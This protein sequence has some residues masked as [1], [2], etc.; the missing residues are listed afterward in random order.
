MLFAPHPNLPARLVWPSAFDGGGGSLLP[1]RGRMRC[2]GRRPPRASVVRP[3]RGP[4][5][6]AAEPACPVPSAPGWV[7]PRANV[8]LG[9]G[10]T[11]TARQAT[12]RTERRWRGVG[13]RGAES[14]RGEGTPRGGGRSTRGGSGASVAQTGRG[15]Q[16][17]RPR[18]EQV[19]RC[20][21]P[22][23]RGREDR[24]DAGLRLSAVAVL[25]T[26]GED[27][28]H[29]GSTTQSRDP[30]SMGRPMARR[31]SAR[32]EGL[33]LARGVAAAPTDRTALR[34]RVEVGALVTTARPRKPR[35]RHRRWHWAAPTRPPRS[36]RFGRRAMSAEWAWPSPPR[37]ARRA[38]HSIAPQRRQAP[39]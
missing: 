20:Q 35:Y 37:V 26:D 23:R 19:P 6:R 33:P 4:T 14:A 2:V 8:E 17:V 18:C 10:R 32:R 28:D 16:C 39:P 9:S 25:E 13:P 15:D 27:L 38:F 21:P 24:C 12:R 5:E 7:P 22:T 1:T 36:G 3:M 11:R 30:S 29:V 34:G 31:A